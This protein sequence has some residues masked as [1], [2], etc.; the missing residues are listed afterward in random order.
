[1]NA[2]PLDNLQQD[3]ENHSLT[4]LRQA[5]EAHYYRQH[6]ES[7]Q[8]DAYINDHSHLIRGDD[9]SI[10]SSLQPNSLITVHGVETTLQNAINIGF[11]NPDG[12]PRTDSGLDTKPEQVEA[13]HSWNIPQQLQGQHA[14]AES[15]I[16][17]EAFELALM[18][19]A[20]KIE[21]LSKAAGV[22]FASTQEMIDQTAEVYTEHGLDYAESRLSNRFNEE[23]VMDW[24][25]S[26]AVSDSQRRLALRGMRQGTYASVEGLL[27]QYR[28]HYG[29]S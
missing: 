13:E 19:D 29:I 25:R 23:H 3:F 17:G 26:N 11:V 12:T 22:P 27:N 10:H 7:A 28:N 9:G 6:A 2:L 24:F 8:L 14:F 18:G 1:M 21:A 4:S 20:K 5:N 16:G 15:L